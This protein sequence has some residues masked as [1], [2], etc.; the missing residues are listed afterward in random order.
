MK[1][2]NLA[3]K[4]QPQ[5]PASLAGQ[6]EGGT[7]EGDRFTRIEDSELELLLLTEFA[8]EYTDWE[9]EPDDCDLWEGECD[10]A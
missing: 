10:L 8:E 4:D 1:Q 9:Q 3:E 5:K 6:E 7:P 2:P